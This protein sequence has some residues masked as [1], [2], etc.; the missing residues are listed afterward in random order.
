MNF[1][2]L[3][4][5]SLMPSVGLALPEGFVIRRFAGPPQIEY[6]TAATAA[7]NG[8]LY[9]SSDKNASL[10]HA[11]GFGK[12]VRATDTDGDG[13]ADRFQDFVPDVNSPRGGHFVDGTLYL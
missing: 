10:G 12:I 8:D 11:K 13:K 3:L 5:L 1:R 9:I 2:G 4:F 7:A 6:P